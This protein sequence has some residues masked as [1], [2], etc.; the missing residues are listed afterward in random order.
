ME[1]YPSC[2]KCTKLPFIERLIQ[3]KCINDRTNKSYEAKKEKEKSF[4]HFV[5]NC[6][7]KKIKKNRFMPTE[8]HESIMKA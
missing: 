2:I 6:K 8:L 5:L 4:I 3:M 7:I 1:L